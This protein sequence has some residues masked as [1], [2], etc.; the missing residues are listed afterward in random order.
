MTTV[1]ADDLLSVK[2]ASIACKVTTELDKITPGSEILL[3]LQ[4]ESHF[5]QVL[6]LDA[7]C[8]SLTFSEPLSNVPQTTTEENGDKKSYRRKM[9]RHK[10]Q[11]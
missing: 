5:P 1:D 4:V 2:Q 10:L 3:H 8:T 6:Q 11:T 7:V 9:A